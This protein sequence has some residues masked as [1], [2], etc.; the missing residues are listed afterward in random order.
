ME[1]KL[2]YQIIFILFILILFA[3]ILYLIIKFKGKVSD[4]EHKIEDDV[5]SVKTD[6]N[7]NSN[8]LTVETDMNQKIEEINEH[9]LIISNAKKQIIEF[10][11]NNWKN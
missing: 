5:T 11:K 1:L 2:I 9:V 7:S 4:K 3:V 8:K 6:L 10:L